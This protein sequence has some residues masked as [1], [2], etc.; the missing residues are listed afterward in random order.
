MG[1]S[2]WAIA[3]NHHSFQVLLPCQQAAV[4]DS[5]GSVVT[6]DICESLAFGTPSSGG[7]KCGLEA[8][9]PVDVVHQ[10]LLSPTNRV[11]LPREKYTVGNLS[12]PGTC[13]QCLQ[14]HYWFLIKVMA[15]S[16]N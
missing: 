12:Y 16:K 11:V 2:A 9:R 15:F 1:L 7:R 5:F 13:C 4:M 10:L 6:V 14:K 3:A 8:G